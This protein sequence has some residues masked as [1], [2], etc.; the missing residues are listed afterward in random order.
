VYT[1]GHL[2]KEFG[3]SRSTLL[4]YDKIGLLSPSGRSEANYRIYIKTDLD[5]LEQIC[6]FR[7]TGLPLAEIG[8]LLRR[9]GKRS[10]LPVLEKRLDALNG[11]I[12][13]LRGRKEQGIPAAEA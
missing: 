2:A 8:R 13:A 12:R 9:A 3:L 5:R 7:R 10:V 11:E 6:T 1:V 4:Y